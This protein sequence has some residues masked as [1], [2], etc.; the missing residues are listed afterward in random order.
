MRESRASR[1]M[2]TL[3]SNRSFYHKINKPLQDF[4]ILW[5]KREDSN[6][7]DACAPTRF[8]VVRL[9]PL[10]HASATNFNIIRPNS[11]LDIQPI[12]STV[13]TII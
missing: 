11:Q 5:R 1:S 9:Q 2:R 13:Y 10:G 3:G 8:R 12:S 6:L 4:F 7:R